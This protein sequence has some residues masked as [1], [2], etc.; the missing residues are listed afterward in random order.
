MLTPSYLKALFSYNR[1]ANRRALVDARRLSPEQFTRDQGHS[2]GSIRDVLVHMMGAE[3]IW[4]E[5]CQ[6]R[7]P[8]ALPD[9]AGFPDVD[10]LEERWQAVHRD[11]VNH[12][13]AQTDDSLQEVISYTTTGGRR[14]SLPRWQ[15]LVHVANHSTHHRGELAAMFALLDVPHQEE[16]WYYYFLKDSGQIK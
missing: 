1:W 9:G 4:L 10:A 2:W 6:G 7:S 15:I 8:S 5:R 12:V 13:Q 16:D 11:L 14:F 3:W